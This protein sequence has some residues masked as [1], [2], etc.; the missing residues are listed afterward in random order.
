M[1]YQIRRETT[2]TKIDIKLSV[3]EKESQIHTGVGFLDHMLS[4][5]SFHSDLALQIDVE[6]DTWV[7]DHHT[8]EDIGIVLGQL[9]RQLIKD[10]VHYTRYGTQYIPMDET[11]ARA[12]VD[13]SGRPYLNFHAHFSKEKVG[14]FDTE[15]VKE[16]FRALVINA[17]LTVHIDLL[18]QG[19]TH[20][21]I[22]AIFKAFAHALK[23]ALR[24]SEDRRIPSSKGVIE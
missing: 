10:K 17:H 9:L 4:L 18:H 24:D 22:E 7:D 2:E 13:I 3:S 6:G 23:Q 15:L 19:N 20:H 1:T 5:W 8:T 14:Q 21:E 12:V 11:L 16:F